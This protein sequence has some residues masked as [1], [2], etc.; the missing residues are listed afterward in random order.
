MRSL[1]QTY[2]EWKDLKPERRKSQIRLAFGYI[3]REKWRV[4]QA[5]VAD[6][7]EVISDMPELPLEW[8]LEYRMPFGYEPP[9]PCSINELREPYRSQTIRDA[10]RYIKQGKWVPLRSDLDHFYDLADHLPPFPEEKIVRVRGER[11]SGEPV[12]RWNHLYLDQQEDL[13]ERL[14][15]AIAKKDFEWVVFRTCEY[16]EIKDL[17]PEYPHKQAEK[18]HHDHPGRYQLWDPTPWQATHPND[19]AM[20]LQL[21]QRHLKQELWLGL[22]LMLIMYPEI[23]ELVPGLPMDKISTAFPEEWRSARANPLSPEECDELANTGS[24]V[25]TEIQRRVLKE[26]FWDRGVR[27][28]QEEYGAFLDRQIEEDERELQDN[29]NVVRAKM[30]EAGIEVPSPRQG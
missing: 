9:V 28:T 30:R 20:I 15:A 19:Q 10:K 16:P 7:P 6:S 12:T 5:V 23:A 1:E 25:P 27:M 21:C 4:V 17:L 24:V 11:K 3:R 14:R 2:P 29:L 18:L 13:M 8:I 26:G 22:R